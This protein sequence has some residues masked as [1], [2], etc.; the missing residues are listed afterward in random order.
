[1]SRKNLGWGLLLCLG[2]SACSMS[3]E[4]VSTVANQLKPTNGSSSQS[5]IL[6]QK[7]TLTIDTITERRIKQSDSSQEVRYFLDI[8]LQ[9]SSNGVLP[10]NVLTSFCGSNGDGCFCRFEW[11]E[12]NNTLSAA[13]PNAP[14]S[15]V[16]FTRT[17]QSKIT[18]AQASL[19]RCA[20]PPPYQVGE[21]A[22]NQDITIDIV[23]KEDNPVSFVSTR[24][25]FRRPTDIID[26]QEFSVMDTSGNKLSEVI[27]YTCHEKIFRGAEVR[28]ALSSLKA[29]P[30]KQSNFAA[31]E[32]TRNIPVASAFFLRGFS[33]ATAPATQ[34]NYFNL[35]VSSNKRNAI[36]SSNYRYECPRVENGLRANATAFP[37]DSTF[38]LASRASKRYPIPVEAR[39]TLANESDTESQ[40]H[41]RCGD[42]IGKPTG[43]LISN[44]KSSL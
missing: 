23:A 2:V 25:N 28:S 6:A 3:A 8:N 40:R 12:S 29:V 38:S 24:K 21:I 33:E 43:G 1:M 30:P 17:A 31:I 16:S 32:E 37:M 4:R 14:P 15:A 34:Q 27:R 44:P 10:V 18:I 41:E 13:N 20:A 22:P 26:N 19:A 9:V 36:V 5:S 39:S 11:K 7:Q 42:E 35:Y